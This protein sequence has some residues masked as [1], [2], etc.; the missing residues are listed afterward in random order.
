MKKLNKLYKNI[1]IEQYENPYMN[2]NYVTYKDQNEN[3]K[4]IRSFEEFKNY[5]RK[6]DLNVQLQ[7]QNKKQNE[8]PQKYLIINIFIKTRQL[9]PIKFEYYNKNNQKY[10]EQNKLKFKAIQDFL[11]KY[12]IT[13]DGKNNYP[14]CILG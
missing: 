2:L 3:K 7:Q 11:Q 1:L 13:K 10:Y 9:D 12:T 8:Q 5:C 4:Q 6:Y 14:I